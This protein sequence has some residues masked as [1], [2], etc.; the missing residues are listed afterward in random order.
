MDIEWGQDGSSGKIY[1]LQARPETVQSR[2]GANILRFTLKS[3]SR[4]LTTGR[5]IGQRLAQVTRASSRTRRK[6]PESERVMSWWP[7]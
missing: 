1:I 3:R 6:C 5:S 4:V 2:A 7:T